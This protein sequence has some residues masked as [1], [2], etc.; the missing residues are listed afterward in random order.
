MLV[1]AATLFLYSCGGGGG[2]SNSSGTPSPG[3]TAAG[4]R[5]I[6]RAEFALADAD[7][8]VVGYTGQ[9]L[10]TTGMPANAGAFMNAI[11]YST[12]TG[13][14]TL[15]SIDPSGTSAGNG[16]T[17][18][19]RMSADGRIVVFTSRATNLVPGI[20]YPPGPLQQIFARDLITGITQLVSID[21]TGTSGANV[22]DVSDRFAVSAN[23]RYV[24][25]ASKANNLVP[26][27]AYSG[28]HN[29]FVR[30]LV[31]GTTELI[32]IGTDGVTEGC[33]G[34]HASLFSGISDDGRYVAFTSDATNLVAGVSY[35]PNI[36][37]VFLRDRMTAS[38]QLISASEDGTQ[39][40]NGFC[41]L[42]DF[43]TATCMT[44]D[45]SAIV[46]SC[47]ATNLISGPAYPANPSDIYLWRRATGTL[48]LVSRSFD[49]SE[50]A[51]NGAFNAVISADGRYVAFQ[52]PAFNLVDGVAYFIKGPGG[53]GVHNIF[54][55][56]RF[57]GN[58]Q[59]VTRSLD[60]TTGA[61]FDTQFPLISADGEVIAFGSTATN[62]SSPSVPLTFDDTQNNAAFW[63]ATSNTVSLASVDAT[64]RPMGHVNPILTMSGNGNLFVFLLNLDR[65]AYIFTRQ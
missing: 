6:D 17:G 45:A 49:G 16:I 40:S 26:G 42:Q 38:T 52:S 64:N 54:R 57:T 56:D 29:V 61:D 1:V 27:I 25:F 23:G 10:D 9:P 34:A 39:A 31:A 21:A 41:N 2:S 48:S 15:V 62:I 63:T 28:Q 37:N 13:S 46:F 11:L 55:W 36:A 19:L 47:R 65:G 43:A 8:S 7:G 60:G 12:S 24:A 33:C 14:K 59:L 22:D 32:S 50:A 20:T 44:R 58:I 30:D 53:P 35:T 51:D 18:A 5:K 4:A 3:S